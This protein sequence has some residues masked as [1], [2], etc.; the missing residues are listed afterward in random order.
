VEDG[1]VEGVASV[2]RDD[3]IDGAEIEVGIED[4]VV[5]GV[6]VGE[7]G[8]AVVVAGAE[9]DATGVDDGDME[10]LVL[11]STSLLVVEIELLVLVVLTK[12]EKPTDEVRALL[13]TVVKNDIG[14]T[15]GDD[16]EV[17]DVVPGPVAG[18]KPN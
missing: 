5:E 2:G 17:A 4:E 12:P 10:D 15:G 7:G 8:E 14:V 6:I 1:V 16:V 3:D 9:E 18:V 11:S 13:E